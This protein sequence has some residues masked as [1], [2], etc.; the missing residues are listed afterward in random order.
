M[1]GL[2]LRLNFSQRAYGPLGY[3]T[4]PYQFPSTHLYTLSVKSPR[5]EVQFWI[6]N[7]SPLAT[8]PKESSKRKQ[9]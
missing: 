8:H 5:P 7:M 3:L 9:W 4:S 2:T 1:M 6:A